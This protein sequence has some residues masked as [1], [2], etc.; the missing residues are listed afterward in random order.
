M[1]TD[2]DFDCAV[3]DGKLVVRGDCD[4]TTSRQFGD[5]IAALD[6]QD[7]ELDLRGVTF[8]D[9]TALGVLLAARQRNPGIRVGDVSQEV[10]IVLK[11]TGTFRYLREPAPDNGS[12]IVV[13]RRRGSQARAAGDSPERPE[14]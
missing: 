6:E 9:S 8:F 11:I 14:L 5:C 2:Y 7:F 12:G 13:M 1:M 10:A 4:L 3:V